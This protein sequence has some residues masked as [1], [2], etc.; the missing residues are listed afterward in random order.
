MRKERGKVMFHAS[1][2]RP[3]RH[4]LTVV[5]FNKSPYSAGWYRKDGVFPC[6]GKGS[7]HVAKRGL[8]YLHG[9]QLPSPLSR[10]DLQIPIL[11]FFSQEGP[12]FL[13]TPGA[14]GR[15]NSFWDLSRSHIVLGRLSLDLQQASS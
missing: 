7:W 3:S 15:Y 14:P 9:K 5:T 2:S 6:A 10:S 8:G 11:N 4:P 13:R 1:A 12:N